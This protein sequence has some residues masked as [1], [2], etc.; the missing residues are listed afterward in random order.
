MFLSQSVTYT[1]VFFSVFSARHSLRP[2]QYDAITGECLCVSLKND[3][4]KFYVYN[5]N[6]YMS[7]LT[8]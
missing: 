8:V 1:V 6:Y 5:T 7:L 3:N 2:G 4:N